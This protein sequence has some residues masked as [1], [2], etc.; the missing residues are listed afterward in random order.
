MS[1]AQ[2]GKK[3]ALTFV[4]ECGR[5]RR[6]DETSSRLLGRT[7]R[8]AREPQLLSGDARAGVNGEGGETRRLPSSARRRIGV[9]GTE[10]R[11]LCLVAIGGDGVATGAAIYSGQGVRC[12]AAGR[13]ARA[14][15]DAERL[16]GW[17]KP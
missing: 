9:E 5:R 16:P 3:R 10:A 11:G 4:Q 2:A 15:A 12:E 8:E 1:T 6:R 13:P 14:R 17:P 7:G